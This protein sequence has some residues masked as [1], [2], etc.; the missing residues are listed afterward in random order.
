M[1]RS[2]FTLVEILIVVMIMGL[3]A[4]VAIPRLS[5]YFEPPL[6]VLQRAI[7]EASD[8]AL[9][10]IPIRLSIKLEG[11]TRRGYMFAEAL[12][13]KEIEE[14]SLSAFLGNNSSRPVVLEWQNV[15]LKNL[16]DNSGW[17]FEPE[18]IY[19]YS[20][21]SCSPARIS[22]AAPNASISEIDEYI[23]TVTGYCTKLDNESKY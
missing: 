21:G 23:L 14:D 4:G 19:F 3:M 1:R 5:F 9:S 6:A 11:T 18:I 22:W 13:Q 15:K 8:K 20:D 2:G 7:E 12:V 10:G 17:R 16:P